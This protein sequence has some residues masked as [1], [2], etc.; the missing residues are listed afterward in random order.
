MTIDLPAVDVVI[1]AYNAATTITASVISCLAQSARNLRVIVVDDGSTDAT[2]ATVQDLAN[3]DSRV[4][5]IRQRNFGISRAMNAGIAAGSA[6]FVARLDA[7]DLSHPERHRLQLIRMAE[8]PDLVALSG[9]Y[10]EITGEGR[11]TGRLHT[12]PNTRPRTRIGC[13]PMNPH[14]ASPLRCSVAAHLSAWDCFGLFQYLKTATFTGGFRRSE[15]LK[16]CPQSLALTVCTVVRFPAHRSRT[17][18]AWR[19]ARKL[20]QYRHVVSADAKPTYLCHP[21]FPRF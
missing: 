3:A 21:R 4:T 12:P 16:I 17:G 7:D 18:A 15:R 5:L 13:L 2:A 11:D 8:Q 10:H 19:S 6:P 1:P 20:L 9:F 14:S